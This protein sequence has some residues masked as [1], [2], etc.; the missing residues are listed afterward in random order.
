MGWGGYE[1][2]LRAGRGCPGG[3]DSDRSK[4]RRNI[5]YRVT[6]AGGVHAVSPRWPTVLPA[7]LGLGRVWCAPKGQTHLSPDPYHVSHMLS[8]SG[9]NVLNAAVEP[10][11][12]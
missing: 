1:G 9:P 5:T 11:C 4:P 10:M 2:K 6:S 7:S 8:I 12:L 3:S